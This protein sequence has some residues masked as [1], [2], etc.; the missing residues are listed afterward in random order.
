MGGEVWKWGRGKDW[1]QETMTMHELQGMQRW[2]IAYRDQQYTNGSSLVR[3]MNWGH[4]N[5][6]QR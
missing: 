5:I 6:R 4:Q 2:G 1:T 3:E